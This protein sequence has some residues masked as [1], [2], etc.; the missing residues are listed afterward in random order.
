MGPTITE[1]VYILWK[2]M[3]LKV[4][5]SGCYQMLKTEAVYFE[6]LRFLA[7]ELYHGV[8]LINQILRSFFFFTISWKIQV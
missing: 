4:L 5:E 6:R 7:V 2:V 3:E 1:Y 8:S